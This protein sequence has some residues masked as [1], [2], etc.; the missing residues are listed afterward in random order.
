MVYTTSSCLQP[1]AAPSCVYCLCSVHSSIALC[2]LQLAVAEDKP[3]LWRTEYSF[4]NGPRE[5]VTIIIIRS[6]RVHPFN[7]S[8]TTYPIVV[9]CR[10]CTRWTRVNKKTLLYCSR[11]SCKKCLDYRRGRI[12]MLLIRYL[13]VI[14]LPP[15]CIKCIIPLPSDLMTAVFNP[16][17]KIRWCSLSIFLCIFTILCG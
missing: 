4:Y 3:A 17:S 10:F 1:H 7:I 9:G 5:V 2:I 15:S 6:C 11:E 12:I 13:F 16:K 14:A 8:R